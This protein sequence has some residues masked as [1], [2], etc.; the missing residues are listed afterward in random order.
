MARCDCGARAGSR[1]ELGDVTR[2]LSVLAGYDTES[3][4]EVARIG[5]SD[6]RMTV[7]PQRNRRGRGGTDRLDPPAPSVCALGVERSDVDTRLHRSLACERRSTEA[8]DAREVPRG[9]DAARGIDGDM[10]GRVVGR[11]AE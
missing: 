4:V 2:E 8:H 1:R 5:T 6:R 11:A 10:V 9:H 7:G 3:D